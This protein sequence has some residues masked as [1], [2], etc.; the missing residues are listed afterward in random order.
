MTRLERK[1]RTDI[2]FKTKG[3]VLDAFD[4][5]VKGAWRIND[6]EYDFISGLEDKYLNA[7]IYD[8]RVRDI[9]KAKECI[10]LI[11]EALEMYKDVQG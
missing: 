4:N 3:G 8:S 1:N 5:E 6:E 9:S 10:R 2:I 7:L 11:N